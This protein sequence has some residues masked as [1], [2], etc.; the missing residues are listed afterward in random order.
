MSKKNKKRHNKKKAPKNTN[1]RFLDCVSVGDRITDVSIGKFDLDLGLGLSNAMLLSTGYITRTGIRY[2][3]TVLIPASSL[4]NEE[5]CLLILDKLKEGKYILC[6]DEI[7]AD[8]VNE[9]KISAALEG[10]ELG[11]IFLHNNSNN[12]N[13]LKVKGIACIE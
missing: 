12:T 1:I 3:F 13:A 9:I 11:E 5:V 6:S 8:Y 2:D 7:T 10:I 4:E